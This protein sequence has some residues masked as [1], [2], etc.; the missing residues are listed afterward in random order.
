[1]Y[2]LFLEEECLC[3]GLVRGTLGEWVG[4]LRV[5]FS[6]GEMGNGK[7]GYRN[8]ISALSFL[9]LLYSFTIVL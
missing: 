8:S 4:Y 2:I 3:Y 7:L 1:M 9:V 5:W 6:T